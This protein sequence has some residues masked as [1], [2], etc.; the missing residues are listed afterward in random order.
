MT[1]WLAMLAVTATIVVGATRAQADVKSGLIT[2]LQFEDNLNDSS[3]K[4]YNATAPKAPSGLF[5]TGGKFGQALDLSFGEATE[6]AVLANS[7]AD[8]QFGAAT[9]FTVS[10]WVQ[11]QTSADNDSRFASFI[12]NMNFF[13]TQNPGWIIA[14]DG[15]KW[16]WAMAD[17]AGNHAGFT[18]GGNIFDGDWYHLAVTHDRTGVASFQR[19]AI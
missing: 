10:F 16:Q 7:Y 1:A 14:Q 13:S 15:E 12:G 3:G 9:D 6:F 18:G 19:T 2:H 8:L 17:A 5:Y 11:K 4:G